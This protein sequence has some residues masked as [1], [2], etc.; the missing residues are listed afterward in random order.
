MKKL[1]LVIFIL[2]V[3]YISLF[4]QAK[5][6]PFSFPTEQKAIGAGTY[7]KDSVIKTI[8]IKI[9]VGSR[10]GRYYV[11]QN[12]KDNSLWDRKYLKKG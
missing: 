8:P 2:L 9:Y 5:K 1:F 3:G 11:V 6:Q 4:A 10:G 12:Q 7:Q